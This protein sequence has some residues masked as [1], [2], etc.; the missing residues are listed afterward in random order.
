MIRP[1]TFDNLPAMSREHAGLWNWFHRCF[2]T[3]R[4]WQPWCREVLGELLPTPTGHEAWIEQTHCLEPNREKVRHDLAG[5]ETAIGRAPENDIV[6]AGQAIAKQHAR[7][8]ETDGAFWIEDKGSTLGT[9]LRDKKLPRDTLQRLGEGDQFT[10][11]PYS[12][13]LRMR[14][15]WTPESK[16]EISGGVLRLQRWNEFAP[17]SPGMAPFGL[18]AH[19]AGDEA[20]IEIERPFL[21][22]VIER[23]LYPLESEARQT[24]ECAALTEFLLL[25]VLDRANR[26]MAFPFRFQLLDQPLSTSNDQT[27]I[28]V[29]FTVQLSGIAGAARLFLPE[30]LLDGM[31]AVHDGPRERN[32]LAVTW[33]FPAIAGW[34]ELIPDELAQLEAGDILL[35]P[36]DAALLWPGF[37]GRGWRVSRTA[38]QHDQLTIAQWMDTEFSMEDKDL[39]QLPVRIHVVLG[40][41]ELTLGEING[42]TEG[43]IVELDR[44]PSDPVWLAVNGKFV[45]E[46][47]LVEI[48]DKLGVKIL[49][50][51][52]A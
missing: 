2:P 31:R 18:R 12:L 17:G 51:K 33:R 16:V 35:Y 22:R 43:S 42:L 24:L 52:G 44:A 48:D 46:G 37:D 25:G 38:D 40:E 21:E 10:I 30:R 50:W 4:E 13:T 8:L 1:Y 36:P 39:D 34:A 20:V 15:R 27:G 49:S 19:P 5:G 45:G 23:L 11:F 3:Q 29:S 9:Y 7:L 28:A 41:K 6:L 32:A 26:D 14:Q 47:E